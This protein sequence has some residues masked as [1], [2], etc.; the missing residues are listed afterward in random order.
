[1]QGARQSASPEGP[2]ACPITRA[3]RRHPTV[4]FRSPLVEKPSSQ[5]RPSA[6]RPRRGGRSPAPPSGAS[7]RHAQYSPT[8]ARRDPAP[9][10]TDPVNTLIERGDAML[11]LHDIGSARLLYER[12]AKAGN[13]R[14]A[15]GVGKTFDPNFLRREGA[16]GLQPNRSEAINWYQKAA[17]WAILRRRFCFGLQN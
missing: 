5:P 14:A 9:A 8:V 10:T 1:M 15:T 2:G 12:A 4:P 6:Q 11:A 7:A 13:S 17:A 3:K 16:V